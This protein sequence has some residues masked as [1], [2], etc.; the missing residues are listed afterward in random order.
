MAARVAQAIDTSAKLEAADQPVLVVWEHEQPEEAAGR[1][2]A[3]IRARVP[4]RAP[5]T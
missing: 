3:V 5:C 1:M 2:A 4:K